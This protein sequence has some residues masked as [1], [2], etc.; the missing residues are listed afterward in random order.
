MGHIC[1]ILYNMKNTDLFITC[2]IRSSADP[3]AG[4]INSSF[5]TVQSEDPKSSALLD[6]NLRVT[7]TL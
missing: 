7:G 5:R 6:Y 4:L 3:K 1:D 2:K